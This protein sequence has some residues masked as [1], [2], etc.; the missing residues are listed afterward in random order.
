MG[1]QLT[2]MVD[3]TKQFFNESMMFMNRCEKPDKK[4]FLKISGSC[5]MGFI[6]MGVIGYCIKLVFIPINNILLN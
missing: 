5:A 6:V 1:K 3:D 2:G 4:E